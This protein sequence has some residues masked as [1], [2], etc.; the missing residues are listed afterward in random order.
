MTPD[1]CGLERE[2][3]GESMGRRGEEGKGEERRRGGE[4]DERGGRGER[5][6][7]G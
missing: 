2:R 5:W 6:V 4:I 7:E 1:H 3:Q